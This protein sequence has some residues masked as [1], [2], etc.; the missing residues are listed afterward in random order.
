MIRKERLRLMFCLMP[1]LL[2]SQTAAEEWRLAEASRFLDEGNYAKVLEL[3][4]PLK[5]RMDRSA[6]FHGLVGVAHARLGEPI[7]AIESLQKALQLDPQNENYYLDLGQVMGENG[8]H[9][10]AIDLL[11]WATSKYPNSARLQVG[12]GLAYLP[13]GRMKEARAAAQ[14]AITLDP[15]LETSYT[16]LAM[17]LED[18]SDWK[19]MLA[20]SRRLQKL[21]PKNYLGWYY[22]GLAL[23]ALAGEESPDVARSA[24]AFRRSTQLNPSFPLAYFQLGKLFLRKSDYPTAIAQ[25]K[26]AVDLNPDYVEANFLLGQAFGKLG[27]QQRSREYLERHRKLVAAEASRQRPH[28][29]VKVN[30]PD[31]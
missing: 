23:V 3:L 30:R 29:E 16:T 20:I 24:R 27:D 31:H 8:A 28:L 15:A 25:L 18:E 13:A 26:R 21:N 6:A 22:E 1:Y 10:A 19:P 14:K 12:L 17:V 4:L 11:E 2:L 5:D 9:G 7:P